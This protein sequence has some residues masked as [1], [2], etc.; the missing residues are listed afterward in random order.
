MEEKE[1]K[2]QSNKNV[3]NF[4]GELKLDTKR[5]REHYEEYRNRIK[6]S[7]RGMI[8]MIEEERVETEVKNN[9]KK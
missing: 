5:K 8:K 2:E 4:E 6:E 7:M 1:E 3:E 9:M